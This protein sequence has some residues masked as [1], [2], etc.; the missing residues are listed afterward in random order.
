MISLQQQFEE[1]ESFEVH[2]FIFAKSSRNFQSEAEPVFHTQIGTDDSYSTG[3]AIEITERGDYIV[4]SF[5]TKNRVDALNAKWGYN[6]LVTLIKKYER[7]TNDV[8]DAR[9]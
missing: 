6:E 3:Y 7:I 9:A 2:G 4:W 1:G 5:E 8:R